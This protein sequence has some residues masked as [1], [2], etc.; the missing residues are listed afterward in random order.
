LG[1]KEKPHHALHCK[2]LISDELGMLFRDQFNF[3]LKKDRYH[4]NVWFRH[5]GH[6]NDQGRLWAAEA[7]LQYLEKNTSVH[8]T[9]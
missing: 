9:P 5:E 1:D 3:V 8:K 6:W 7:A 2:R 4:K